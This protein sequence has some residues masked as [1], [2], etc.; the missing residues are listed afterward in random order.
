MSKATDKTKMLG[1]ESIGKLLY[2]LSMPATIGMV[3]MAMYNIVD[4]IFVGRG[5]GALAIAGLSVVFPIQM[6]ITSVAQTIGIGGSSIISRALGAKNFEKASLTFGNLLTLVITLSIF[7]LPIG[8]IFIDELLYVFGAKGDIL[9]YAKDYFKIV[10]FGGPFLS[11][12]MM[13]NN[14][15]RSEGN[16]RFAMNTMIVAAIINLIFDPIFIFGLELG[17]KGAAYATVLSQIAA[18][19]YC[20]YYFVAGKSTLSFQSKNLRLDFTIVKETFAIG[21]SSFARQIS[22]S[23][24]AAIL[25][26]S[27]VIYGGEIAVAVFGVL[28]KIIMMAFMPM[29]GILQG[30]LPIVG[31]NYGASDYSRVRRVIRISNISTTIIAVIGFIAVMLFAGQTISVFSKDQNLIAEGKNALRIIILA[32]PLIGFQ[33]IGSG[34]FQALG[35]ALPSFFLSIS[36]QVL[37]LIPLVIVLPLYF[38]LNGIWIAFPLADSLSA[39]VTFFMLLPQLRKL[40]KEECNENMSTE[41]S[42]VETR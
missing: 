22:G 5:V 13:S 11:F 6:I 16:A 34:F 26:H 27:L 35:K 29:F 33:M 23:V 17:I 3:V 30:F 40:K 39:V 2:K 32:F 19:L 10:I 20:V 8:L 25:N 4:T 1:T 31:Y 37:F 36:R 24:M 42:F 12:A 15:I 28:H 7:L 18:A 41:L 9:P 14:I 21:A 38:G